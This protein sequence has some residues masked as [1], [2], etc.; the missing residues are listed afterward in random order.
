MQPDT[1]AGHGF[2]SMGKSVAIIQDH[3]QADFLSFVLLDDLGLE[4]AAYLNDL[5]QRC[6]ISLQNRRNV[7]FQVAEKGFIQYYAVLDHLGQPAAVLALGQG[8]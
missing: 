3:P 7:I 4:L 1:V 2:K 6:S 5:G 8:V